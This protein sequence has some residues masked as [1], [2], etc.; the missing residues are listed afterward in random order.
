M[1][2][3]I[4]IALGLLVVLAVNFSVLYI[5]LRHPVEIEKSY[6]AATR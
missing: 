4:G 6:H 1:R 2:W 5:A 3:P